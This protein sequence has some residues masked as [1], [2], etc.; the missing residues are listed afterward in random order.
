MKNQD[1][2][3]VLIQTGLVRDRA[4]EFLREF[5]KLD[6]DDH[7][8]IHAG[9]TE[10]RVEPAVVIAFGDRL[11][12]FTTEQTRI[13]AR[14]AEAVLQ[15]CPNATGFANLILALRHGADVSDRLFKADSDG[16]QS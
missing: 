13:I 10:D 15:D 9:R 8:Q 16:D 3:H 5:A 2:D 12:G 1:A 14:I 6:D 11:Y 4:Q 7:I